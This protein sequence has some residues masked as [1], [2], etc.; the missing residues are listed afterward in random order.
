MLEGHGDGEHL[1]AFR[2][3]LKRPRQPTLAAPEPLTLGDSR[4][5]AMLRQGR[6]KVVSA[7]T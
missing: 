4:Y 1:C 3:I 6:A 5:A 2:E 7:P